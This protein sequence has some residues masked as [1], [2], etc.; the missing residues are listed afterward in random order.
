ME[1][2]ETSDVSSLF[3]AFLLVAYATGSSIS[4]SNSGLSGFPYMISAGH[5]IEL[6]VFIDEK[7][8]VGF[9]IAYIFE[10]PFDLCLAQG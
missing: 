5:E 4:Q 2:E 7:D 3:H 10:N 6:A 8:T 9:P 1:R